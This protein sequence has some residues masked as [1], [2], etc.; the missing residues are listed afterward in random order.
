MADNL[1]PDTMRQLNEQMANMDQT[2]R[3]MVPAMVLM[4]ASLNEL[5]AAQK[6]SSISQ[7]DGKKIVD[8]FL[9]SQQEAT[10]ATEANNKAQKEKDRIDANYKTAKEQAIVGLK[11]F[12]NGL[13]TI[14]GGMAKYNQALG[15]AGDAALSIGKNF[16]ILGIAAG[17]LIKVFS[18]AAEMVLK[19]ND[20]ILK[21]TD[22]LAEFGATGQYTADEI[23]LMGRAAGYSSGELE[24]WTKATKSMGTSIIA[25][26]GTVNQGIGAFA[27]LTQM[28]DKEYET[29]RALGVSQEQLTQNQADYIKL[30]NKSGTSIQQSDVA[31]GR[32]RKATIEYTSY[33]LDLS[34]ITGLSVEEAKKAQQVARD[35]LAVQTRLAIMDDKIIE[36]RR[37]GLD[38]DADRLAAEKKRTEE[39][40]DMAGTFMKGEEL[41]GFQSA[42]A[43]GNWN[44]IS[45]GFASGA[46]E[47]QEFVKAVKDG[48]KEPY[49]LGLV[50]ANATERTRKNVGEAIIQN[51]EIGKAFAYSKEALENEAKYRGKSPEEIAKT[52]EEERAKRKKGVDDNVQAARN[53]QETTERRMRIAADGMV[54]II[55]GP[56]TNAFKM[57]MDIIRGFAKGLAQFSDKMFGTKLAQLFETPEDIKTN[58]AD[59]GKDIDKLQSQLKQETE[60]RQNYLAVTEKYNQKD[61]EVQEARLAYNEMRKKGIGGEEAIAAKK[62]VEELEKE[63]S[64][65]ST[66]KYNLGRELE[67]KGSLSVDKDGK[68]ATQVRLEKQLGEIEE[69][70]NK[71]LSELAQKESEFGTNLGPKA[72]SKEVVPSPVSVGGGRGSAASYGV[73]SAV[74]G[75]GVDVAGSNVNMTDYLKKIAMVES[76]GKADA[77]AKTSS[78]S[79]LFQFTEGTWNQMTK[80]MGKNYTLQDRF[81]PKKAAE[82][83]AYFTSQQKSQL[84]K[85]TGQ[86][87]SE[88]DLYMAHFLGAGGA[89]R[90][91]NALRAN[92]DGPA[93]DGADPK[94]VQANASIFYDKK[95]DIRSLQQ[96]YDLMS[97]KV[98]KAGEQVASGKVSK[99]I[100]EIQVPEVKTANSGGRF[101]GPDS[102]YLVMLHGNEDVV[103]KGNSQGQVTKEALPASASQDMSAFMEMMAMLTDKLDDMVNILSESKDTQDKLLQYSRV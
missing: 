8:D 57:F 102:G 61:K 31:N 25:F 34:A 75:E 48:K 71:R 13:L 44:E 37:K 16:G 12:G 84:E 43:T 11:Q 95:G 62:K 101:S 100:Q 72:A 53:A 67:G 82:V 5:I 15:S 38:Q 36:L 79:G 35:D 46:P 30:Q 42:V 27:K 2:V 76:G 41:A 9:K 3:T 17:G 68:T 65:L 21:A 22:S 50:M 23:K 10:A 52:I 24:K 103:P 80:Q 91:L 40:L 85:G 69:K 14:G 49:E 56:V 20:D 7:K 93:S 39:L 59:M 99:D 96:V 58:V 4:T 18:V 77:K 98:S 90:F 51:K 87:A 45:K 89:T 33:L 94:Q 54:D 86:S 92:P 78:A 66:K 28:T 63:R 29:F 55:K 83:A 19:Q 32:L 64:T 26:G 6:G 60:L 74:A 97:N 73:K 70:R 81:D 1:D 47:L 88:A